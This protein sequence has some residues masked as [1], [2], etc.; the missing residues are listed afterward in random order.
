MDEV[1]TSGASGTDVAVPFMFSTIPWSRPLGESEAFTPY[2]P[3][4]SWCT[5]C[6]F[7]SSTG[8]AQMKKLC[9]AV[10]PP[11][12]GEVVEESKQV[13]FAAV[14]Q[15]KRK[16]EGAVCDS[17]IKSIADV[18]FRQE[19]TKNV[20][21]WSEQ[22]NIFVSCIQFAGDIGTKIYQRVVIEQN[23]AAA[24]GVLRDVLGAKSPNHDQQ[25]GKIHA[26]FVRVDE[27]E[28]QV[29]LALRQ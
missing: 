27:R 5:C 21:P 24:M 18:D 2:P 20:E 16:R 13:L 12:G 9:F 10:P 8:P 4:G 19:P 22:M 26:L 29:V 28:L 25:K 3:L 23:V 7:L 6:N 15:F 11:A 17:V 1:A 14:K